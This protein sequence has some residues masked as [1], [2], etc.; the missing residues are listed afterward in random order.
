MRQKRLAQA[1]V[2]NQMTDAQFLGREPAADLPS[3]RVGDGFEGA[4]REALR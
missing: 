3:G 1:H 4:A 2:L